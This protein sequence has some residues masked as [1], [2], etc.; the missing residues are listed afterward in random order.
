MSVRVSQS[1]IA[2]I[3]PFRADP[4]NPPDHGHGPGD[5]FLG[6]IGRGKRPMRVAV[7]SGLK[8]RGDFA[9]KSAQNMPV[10]ALTTLTAFGYTCLRCRENVS[11][12]AK[13]L[14]DRA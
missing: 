13:D 7:F 11:G 8:A 3:S 6:P 14:Y 5:E 4:V 12:I 9:L 1:L 10:I 2:F